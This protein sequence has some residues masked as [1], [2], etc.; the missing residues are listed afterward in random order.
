MATKEWKEENIEKV[1]EYRRNW[2]NRNKKRQE[3]KQ[4]KENKA[5]QN[6]SKSIRA[7]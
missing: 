3:T 5:Q 7:H 2:Y 1:R 6:G 4:M